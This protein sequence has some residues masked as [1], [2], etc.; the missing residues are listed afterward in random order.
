MVSFKNMSTV[1]HQFLASFTFNFATPNANLFCNDSRETSPPAF[2]SAA[3]SSFFLISILLLNSQ[4]SDKALNSI[5]I[6]SVQKHLITFIFCRYEGFIYPMRCYY[7]SS[8]CNHNYSYGNSK[9]KHL[10]HALCSSMEY[11]SHRNNNGKLPQCSATL[12]KV[13]TAPI[14]V[15]LFPSISS[16]FS[17]SFSFFSDENCTLY[18][19]NS[20]YPL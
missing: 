6:Y 3:S 16:C 7:S 14:C 2:F 1:L 13:M 18:S 19:T 15:V 12:I 4:W 17:V 11:G 20:R 8:D 10:S 5:Y 9:I